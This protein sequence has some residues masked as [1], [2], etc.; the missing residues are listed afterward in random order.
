MPNDVK[1]IREAAA[2]GNA[3]AQL[4]LQ[5]FTRSITKAIGGFQ[6]LLGGLDALVFTGGIGEHDAHTRDEI[7]VNLAPL[8][9][10]LATAPLPAATD[11]I[12]TIS[13]SASRTQVLVIPAQEDLMIALH[14]LRLSPTNPA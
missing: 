13:D 4:A 12:Q 3:D 5:V 10:E 11:G 7:L 1:A 9:V 2:A 8:G 6:W 14:V